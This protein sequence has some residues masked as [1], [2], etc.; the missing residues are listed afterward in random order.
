[1]SENVAA[2]GHEHFEA[3]E[4][5]AGH[6]GPALYAIIAVALVILTLMELTVYYVAFLQPL[7]VP[8]LILLAIAKFLLVGGFYMHLYYDQKIFSIF[9]IFPIILACFIGAALLMIF[10]ALQGRLAL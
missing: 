8:I 5:H 6:P 2:A 10:S 9:F 3:G 7:L 4:H 1:M